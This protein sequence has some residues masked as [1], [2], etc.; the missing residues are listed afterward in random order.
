MDTSEVYIKMND[1]LPGDFPDRYRLELGD[2]YYDKLEGRVHIFCENEP[3]TLFDH[4]AIV[5]LHRQDQLQEMVDGSL[6]SKLVGLYDFAFT[7]SLSACSDCIN[8]NIL[9]EW[10]SGGDFY[11]QAIEAVNCKFTSMEQLLLG[12][13][14]KQKFNKTWNGDKW[15]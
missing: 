2:Y 5:K 8:D 3:R 12:Y 10:A 4:P 7:E 11:N 1:T 15:V 6:A 9:N 13:V 14:V